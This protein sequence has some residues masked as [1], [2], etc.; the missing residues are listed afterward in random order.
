MAAQKNEEFGVIRDCV[1]SFHR[2]TGLGALVCAPEGNV[3]F[4]TGRHC[5]AC[6]LCESLDQP[7]DVCVVARAQAWREA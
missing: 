7:E 4:E 1:D 2:V 5:R 6:T 3:L